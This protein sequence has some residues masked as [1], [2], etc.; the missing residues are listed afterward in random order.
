M[1]CNP[2]PIIHSHSPCV[3]PLYLASF[4][5]FVFYSVSAHIVGSG[6]RVWCAYLPLLLIYNF[7]SNGALQ[8]LW[9]ELHWTLRSDQATH[10]SRASRQ[11]TP[12]LSTPFPHCVGVEEGGHGWRAVPDFHVRVTAGPSFFPGSFDPG[13]CSSA[14]LF[15]K[16]MFSFKV[17]NG[18]RLLYSHSHYSLTDSNCINDLMVATL[19]LTF[20]ST[21]QGFITLQATAFKIQPFVFVTRICQN[22]IFNLI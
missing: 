17:Q 14:P 18:H 7:V 12:V 19:V 10:M 20:P 22:Y 1:T 4:V 13:P 15:I 3:Q 2:A 21:S 5:T 9:G 6:F 16:I 11:Y 8:R